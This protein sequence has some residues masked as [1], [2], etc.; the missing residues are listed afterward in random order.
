MD[1]VGIVV[2]DLADGH[3]RLH[4]H[5]AQGIIIALAEQLN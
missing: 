3:A 4:A 5:G 1:Q 2:D